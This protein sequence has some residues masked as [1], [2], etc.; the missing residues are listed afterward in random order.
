MEA[1]EPK[2]T[3]RLLSIVS[4]A[5]AIIGVIACFS[6]WVGDQTGISLF[7][8]YGEGFQRF[9]PLLIVALAAISVVVSSFT[10]MSPYNMSLLFA[11]F[12]IG[13]GMMAFTSIFAMWEIDAIRVTELVSYGF[14]MTYASGAAIILGASLYYAALARLARLSAV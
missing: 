12:F 11:Q 10:M 3:L 8:S 6:P 2:T 5:G 7:V 9:I 1:V 14:W 13:V 4:I